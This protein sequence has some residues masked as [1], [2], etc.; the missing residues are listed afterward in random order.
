MSP[1][2]VKRPLLAV[3]LITQVICGAVA[4]QTGTVGPPPPPQRTT[5]QPQKS[6]SD[7]DVVKITT[8]LVQVDAVVTD[9]NGKLVTDLKPEEVENY[10]NGRE[11]KI[12]NFSF[13]L[14]E[15]TSTARD[16]K[17]TAADKNAP[18]A[19]P[20]RLRTEDIRR[21]IALVVD[22]LGLSFESTYYVRRALKKFVDEQLDKAS[23]RPQLITQVKL[24]RDGKEIF[25][26]KE[27]PYD[28]SGQTDLQRLPT[29]GAIQ[30]GNG[31]EPGD[32]VLQLIVT[33]PLA[34]KKHRIATQWMDFQIVK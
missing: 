18:A 14:S 26:G 17:P 2:C 22:D 25:S 28:S 13:N 20:S 30:L 8:N 6:E 27:L 12:T 1:Q 5:Q 34:D 10:E 19:P 7:D 23:T 29:G 33:D 32:Y 24:F 15:S 31:M 9:K 4:Q 11:Q 21:T 16:A 3:L